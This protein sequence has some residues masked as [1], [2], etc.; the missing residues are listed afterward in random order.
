MKKFLLYLICLTSINSFAQINEDLTP[1]ERAYLF[2]VVKK[3]PILN[4]N[5]GRFF[6]YQGP[7]ILFT[8]KSINYDSI[9]LLIIN[10]PELLVVRKEE[11]AK[12]AK[13]LIAEAANKMAVW[14]LNNVLMA[15]RDEPDDL[16]QYKNEY[17]YFESLL[18]ANLPPNA[19]KVK[20]DINQPHPKLHNIMNPNMTLDDKTMQLGAMKFLSMNDQMVTLNAIN[21]AING[22]VEKRAF[23]IFKAL[24]GKASSFTNILVAAGDGSNTEGILEEREKDERG[25]WNKGL[26]KAVGL[27]PYQ[28]YIDR[29]EEKKKVTEKLESS[30]ITMN[31]FNS[32]GGNK[33]TNLHFDVWGYNS[34]KQTTVVIEKNGLNY[35]LFGSKDTRF[36]SPD[37]TFSEGKTFQAIINDLEFNKIGKIKELIYGKKGYDHWIEYNQKKK[38]ATEL[39]IEKKEKEYSDLGFSPISTST[40]ASHRVKKSKRKAIKTG[41]R[42]FDGAPT[43]NSNRKERKDLQS[44][45]VGLYNLFEAYKKKIADL[46]K[47]KAEAIDLMA[48]YQRKLDVYKQAMG[49]RWA[50][51][52]EENGLYT[53]EDSTTFDITTQEFQFKPTLEP[54]AFEVRLIAIPESCLSKLADEVMLH[55]NVMDAEPNY[56]ARI[57]LELLDVFESDKWEL[58]STLFKDNDS[59]ALRIF[60]EGLLDKK[61]PFE[62]I[63]R[64]QGIGKW[65][66][67]QTIKDES[68]KELSRYPGNAAISKMDSSFVRLRKSEVLIHIDRSIVMEVNSF[69]DPVASSILISDEE[70]TSAMTKYKL[71]KNDILSAYRTAT[72]LNTLKTEINVLA[73]KYL[74]REEAKI[75]IDRFNK[76]WLKTRINVGRTSFKLS[77]F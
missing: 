72:I 12:S 71:S 44:T 69:T 64:G 8:N 76:L 36:L 30:R 34:E 49:I 46:E 19:T 60:F 5:F 9:E 11:I 51:Y 58:K 35:H 7:E 31:N 10:K 1:E 77:D 26:P 28:L 59:I 40:K 27:F 6:D 48:I 74:N 61:I 65:N 43:T 57:N 54:E 29:T 41:A 42:D 21:S 14:E 22:Y 25:R 17:A 37:S 75:V 39:K 16:K 24:G 23:E 32:A 45:I 38:D 67:V 4:N 53:F 56:D 18:M 47:E 33:N 55:I 20:N 68:P 62:I 50:N 73:G 63:A 15:K 70:I 13:G 3:S 2:H 52:T 66:G